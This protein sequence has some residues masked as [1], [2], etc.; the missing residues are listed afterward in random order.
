MALD[1]VHLRFVPSHK[2]LDYLHVATGARHVELCRRTRTA[3]EVVSAVTGNLLSNKA[4]NR[5]VRAYMITTLYDSISLSAA[6]WWHPLE[7]NEEKPQ[8]GPRNRARR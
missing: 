8:S 5:K 2:R 6:G 1:D 4:I 7:Q 3:G